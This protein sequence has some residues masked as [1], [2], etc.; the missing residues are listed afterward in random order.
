MRATGYMAVINNGFQLASALTE[1]KNSRGATG[2][3]KYFWM[4]NLAASLSYMTG[5]A[6]L[7]ISPKDANAS[8]SNEAKDLIEN[9]YASA[10][11][12]ILNQPPERQEALLNKMAFYL[13]SQPEIRESQPEIAQKL[14]DK[15][16]QVKD[17]PWIAIPQP[18]QEKDGVEV[19]S[20]TPGESA[21]VTSMRWRE[22]E[23][24]TRSDAAWADKENARK[25]AVKE[26]SLAGA[27]R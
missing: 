14:Q 15:L 2:R 11:G 16:A 22:R 18:R 4:F 3:S 6:L 9:V 20:H 26:P 13:S 1:R 17:S 10:A 19:T 5:N 12:I 7:A 23:A 24:A 21:G 27:A 8:M 25:E